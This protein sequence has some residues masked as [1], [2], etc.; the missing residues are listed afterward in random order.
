MKQI[1]RIFFFL[2]HTKKSQIFNRYISYLLRPLT[3]FLLSFKK[4]KKKQNLNFF[5]INTDNSIYQDEK[6]IFKNQFRFLGTDP[7]LVDL[8]RWENKGQSSLWNFNL[9]Y[10]NHL[11]ELITWFKKYQNFSYL[12]KGIFF[13][14]KWINASGRFSNILW[15]PYTISLRLLNWINFYTFLIENELVKEIPKKVIDSIQRQNTFL[16]LNLEFD[17]RGNHLFENL[18]TIILTE[19][20]FNRKSSV[21]K[22]TK[23][24]N[25][26]LSKQLHTDGCHFEKSFSYHII[27]LKGIIDLINEI[28]F[29]FN[30]LKTLYRYG[31][32]NA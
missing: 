1:N 4:F 27:I 5:I 20:F 2:L 22:Y 3:F 29:D 23:I 10:F 15:S 19:Y 32:I 11:N 9:N 16:K 25:K 8:N 24:M 28:K 18:K 26:E 12:E 30:S 6:L 21:D 7:Y 13:I 31:I 14:D 17:V